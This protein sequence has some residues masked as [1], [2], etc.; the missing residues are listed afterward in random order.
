MAMAGESRELLRQCTL[1]LPN[2]E[3]HVR[4]PAESRAYS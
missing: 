2:Q 1:R 3:G 4:Y